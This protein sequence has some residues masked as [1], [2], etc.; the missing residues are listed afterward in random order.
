[1]LQGVVTE[2][3]DNLR[4]WLRGVLGDCVALLESGRKERRTIR[5]TDVLEVL[6][7]RGSTLYR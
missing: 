4:L 7:R 3:S 6:R 2:T 1:M 5:E